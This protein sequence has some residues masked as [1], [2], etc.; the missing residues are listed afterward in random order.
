MSL[1]APLN[2]FASAQSSAPKTA[3]F[4][5]ITFPAQ[6]KIILK[7]GPGD[8][9]IQQWELTQD[10]IKGLVKDCLPELLK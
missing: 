6:G 1:A 4:F 10:D 7:V 5:R 2:G 9:T 3:R 8:H